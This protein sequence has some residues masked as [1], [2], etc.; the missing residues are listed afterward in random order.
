MSAS[1]RKRKKKIVFFG[2][3]IT[4]AG[5]LFGGYIQRI[6]TY[7]HNEDVAQKFELIGLG[8]NGNKVT[9]L[10]NRLSKDILEKG[11]DLVVIY[12]GINDVWHKYTH[13][14]GTDLQL[15]EHTYI[16][17]I[18]KLK[19]ASIK[20][21]LC[22]PTVIGELKAGLNIADADLEAYSEV[23]RNLSVKYELPLVDLRTTFTN[24]L[25]ENNVENIP[26]GL[27]TTDG[28]H[29]NEKGNQ[30]VANEIWNSIKYTYS[31]Y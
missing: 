9:D 11:C 8:I 18:E 15:F 31:I 16:S 5:A 20:T 25:S 26:Y 22:T 19:T 29:L 1:Y 6:S 28:V 4:V 17:I 24:Y 10:Y 23:I 12:I 2:D 7:L 27:L 13:Q 21:V 14:S 3:S 30:M